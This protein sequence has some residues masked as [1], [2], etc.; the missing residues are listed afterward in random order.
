[1]AHRSEQLKLPFRNPRRV[2]LLVDSIELSKWLKAASRDVT[3][4]SG[5][6][7]DVWKLGETLL[8]SIPGRHALIEAIYFVERREAPS[9]LRNGS[10]FTDTYLRCLQSTDVEVAYTNPRSMCRHIWALGADRLSQDRCDVVAVLSNPDKYGRWPLESVVRAG[11]KREVV[12][13]VRGQVLFFVPYPLEALRPHTAAGVKY[14]YFPLTRKHFVRSQLQS[15]YRLRSG[16][17]VSK[18]PRW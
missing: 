16:E 3:G 10:R 8:R 15:P 11:R 6:W 1:M 7:L 9:H 12:S 18:P 4:T 13:R 17:L 5:R 14:R 2:L